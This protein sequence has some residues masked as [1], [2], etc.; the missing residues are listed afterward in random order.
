MIPLIVGIA[1]L[2]I[3]VA[4]HA[5]ATSLILGLLKRYGLPHHQQVGPALRPLILG[6]TAAFLAVKHYLDIVLWAVAYWYFA[7]EAEFAN[8][9][10]TVYFSSVTYTTLGYGDIVLTNKWRMVCGVEAMNGILLFGWSTAL[11]FLLVQHL[12]FGRNDAHA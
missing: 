8:F 3:T 7:G 10:S 12:W 11:L 6:L 1:G 2:A 5:T 9:E 4:L